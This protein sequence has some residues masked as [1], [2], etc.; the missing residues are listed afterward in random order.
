MGIECISH[1]GICVRDC[2]RSIGFYRDLLGFEVVSEGQYAGEPSNTLLQLE[3]VDL[4]VAYLEREGT[5]IELL[6][7]RSPG[8]EGDSAARPV[9]RLGLTHLSFRVRD[10]DSLVSQ[11]ESAGTPILLNRRIEVPE[12]HTRA[13]FI[14]DPDGQPIE[15]FEAPGD[16]TRPPGG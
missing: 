15:L 5:R 13:V 12:F 11:L 2:D 1:I 6:E 14:T 4:R 3:D 10:L 16:P 8:P 7:F 9:N